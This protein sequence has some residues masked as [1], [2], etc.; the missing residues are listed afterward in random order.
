M[1]RVL[2]GIAALT[3]IAAVFLATRGHTVIADAKRATNAPVHG[4]NPAATATTASAATA[5]AG[6][7]NFFQPGPGPTTTILV[8]ADALQALPE[9]PVPL[10]TMK[11]SAEEA[12]V[13]FT[14][15]WESLLGGMNPTA[16]TRTWLSVVAPESRAEQAAAAYA[17]VAKWAEA[18]DGL[19]KARVYPL[20]T[21]MSAGDGETRVVEV[22]QLDVLTMDGGWA[23]SV[24]QTTVMTLKPAGDGWQ[25]LRRTEIRGPAPEAVQQ[26]SIGGTQLETVLGS[27]ARVQSTAA[28]RSD[29]PSPADDPA[30]QAPVTA[31][32]SD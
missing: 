14:A 12:A 16:A 25:L 2:A 28:H 19:G 17:E 20:A 15:I 32:R 9:V 27:Y 30:G 22:W 10:R 29:E 8:P 31:Q 5:G 1:K 4:V 6:D 13:R 21:K 18:S 23:R 7:A 26:P 3:V 11:L 24:Y